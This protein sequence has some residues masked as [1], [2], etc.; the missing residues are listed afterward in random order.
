LLCAALA[1]CADVN[2]CP[3]SAPNLVKVFVGGAEFVAYRD[4]DGPWQT[5]RVDGDQYNLCVAHDYVVVAACTYS[6]GAFEVNQYASTVGICRDYPTTVAT[7]VT[8]SGDMV[9]PGEVWIGPFFGA[10]LPTPGPWSF[11]VPV[12]PGTHA[13]VAS[14]DFNGVANGRVA[15]RRDQVIE[16]DTTEP[17]IDLDVEGTA[18]S[19]VGL[20][21]TN[22]LADETLST[23]TF[24]AIDEWAQISSTS[25]TVAHVVPAELLLP[26]DQQNVDVG[27]VATIG[28]ASFRRGVDAIFTG[29][30]SFTLLDRL[31]ETALHDDGRG[32]SLPALPDGSAHAFLNVTGGGGSTIA[33]ASSGWLDAHATLEVT[34]DASA[35]GYDPAWVVGPSSRFFSR[36]LE[37]VVNTE[38]DRYDTHVDILN[39]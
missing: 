1:S 23:S 32:A 8:V 22:G 31:P 33:T 7:T 9:Q 11:H 30:T 10:L 20:T 27:A 6:G 25:S 34:F 21:I 2:P 39:Q 35:P 17:V 36:R 5:P 18:T 29:E 37:V 3:E 26:T 16:G 4:G 19:H 12:P 15:I 14:S 24:L 13:L 38:A 28:R